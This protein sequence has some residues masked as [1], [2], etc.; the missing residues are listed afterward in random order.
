M[1]RSYAGRR[2]KAII[3]WFN[4]VPK[5]YFPKGME[6]FKERVVLVEDI[7]SAIKGARY[8]PTVA[9]LG[10]NISVA[11]I[12]FLAG[13]FDSCSLCLDSDAVRHSIELAKR[14]SLLFKKPTQVIKLDKDIKDMDDNDIKKLLIY[15]G[16]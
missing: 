13:M 12:S 14:Y 15:E 6:L 3:Y 16:V 4:D 9:I 11:D 1:D 2:P 8:V 10:T 7:I 5:L